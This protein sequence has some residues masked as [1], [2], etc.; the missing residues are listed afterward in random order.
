MRGFETVETAVG[1][2]DADG[3]STVGAEGYR[4]EAGGYGVGGAARGT[5]G[6]VIGVVWV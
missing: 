4:E 5:A 2:G 1:G 6:V 3:T